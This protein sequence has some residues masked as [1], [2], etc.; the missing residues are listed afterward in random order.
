LES[1]YRFQQGRALDLKSLKYL[2][3]AKIRK[4]SLEII[5][6]KFNVFIIEEIFW[7]MFKM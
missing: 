6:R 5:K 1:S 3:R 7:K 2:L 4:K